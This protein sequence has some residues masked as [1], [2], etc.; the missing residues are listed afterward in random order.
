M[1]LTLWAV[2]TLMLRTYSISTPKASDIV[3]SNLRYTVPVKFSPI[4]LTTDFILQNVLLTKDVLL[5]VKV[6][7]FG[8]AKAVNGLTML[9]VC[10]LTHHLFTSASG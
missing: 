3:I 4:D 10:P 2:P 1:P 5:I 6:A 9:R 7:D 8:L